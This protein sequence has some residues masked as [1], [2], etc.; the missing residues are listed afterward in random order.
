MKRHKVTM[1]VPTSE[2]DK[3]KAQV[4][5]CVNF[6]HQKDAY[7]AMKVVEKLTLDHF[8]VYIVHLLMGKLCF[9]AYLLS[10]FNFILDL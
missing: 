6:I 7:I 10:L 2:R 9:D 8:H 5:T 4:A 1:L 3:R